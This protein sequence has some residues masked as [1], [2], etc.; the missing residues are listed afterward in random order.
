MSSTSA[1][2]SDVSSVNRTPMPAWRGGSPGADGGV[3]QRTTPRPRI[4]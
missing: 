4:T 2:L 1:R 3:V